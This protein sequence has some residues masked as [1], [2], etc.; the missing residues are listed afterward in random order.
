[1]LYTS[2]RFKQ[3][4][5]CFTKRF[6]HTTV[7][8]IS[9]NMTL[10]YIYRQTYKDTIIRLEVYKMA[11]YACLKSHSCAGHAPTL[12]RG[13]ARYMLEASSLP[14]GWVGGPDF[15]CIGS[16]VHIADRSGAYMPW[17]VYRPSQGMF[18]NS[19]SLRMVIGNTKFLVWT[20]G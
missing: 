16:P 8:F 12:A 9:G 6:G 13:W 20:F 1:M 11:G 10:Q 5:L 15:S 3:G 19:R 2:R 4:T 17:L 14:R 7:V 18:S